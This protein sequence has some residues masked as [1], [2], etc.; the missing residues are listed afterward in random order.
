MARL[1]RQPLAHGMDECA[2]V[3]PVGR[4]AGAAVLPPLFIDDAKIERAAR[5]LDALSCGGENPRRP[6]VG[7][8]LGSEHHEPQCVELVLG[9][10]LGAGRRPT[11]DDD[12]QPV[13][14]AVRV[15]LD[16]RADR[17]RPCHI[18]GGLGGNPR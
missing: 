16:Q 18:R 8:K 1:S 15:G 5:H 6:G 2:V 3:A 4:W 14:E 9:V 10:L 17:S 13:V 11:R 12:F 7:A